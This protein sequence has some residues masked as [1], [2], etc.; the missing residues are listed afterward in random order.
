[1][2][3]AVIALLLFMWLCMEKGLWISCSKQVDGSRVLL[4]EAHGFARR[5][6]YHHH[7][8][9]LVFAAMRQFRER[10][11]AAGYDVTYIEADTFGDGLAEFFAGH[12]ETTLVAM[13]SP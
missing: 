9:T 2:P 5:M 10:L 1:M 12:P 4:V 11:R 13:R 7:K 3:S 8:L 6:P